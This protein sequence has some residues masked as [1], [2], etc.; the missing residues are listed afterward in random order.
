MEQPISPRAE[1]ERRRAL[2]QAEVSKLR[3][4]DDKVGSVGLWAASILAILGVAALLGLLQ[5]VWILIPVA[6]MIVARI[7][8]V[9]YDNRIQVLDAGVR[10]YDRGLARMEDRWAGQGRDGREYE[11]ADHIYAGDLDLFGK[12]S[13]F[14]L[15]CTVQTRTGEKTLASWLLR[16]GE[17]AEIRERQAAAKDLRERLDLRE[18]LAR[19]GG[20]IAAGVR[21]EELAEWGV[22]PSELS[23]AIKVLARLLT[24]ASLIT[25]GLFLA[26]VSP[27]PFA[28]AILS[29]LMFN[30]RVSGR[31]GR[32]TGLAERAER[33]LDLV[34]GVLHRVGAE[35]LTSPRLR[36]IQESMRDGASALA[37]L[38]RLI[39][40][41]QAVRNELVM[42]LAGL[43]L[44]RTHCAFALE[45][46]RA[47]WGRDVKRWLEAVGEIEALGALAVYAYENPDDPFPEIVEQGARFDGEQLGHP[48]LPRRSCV[49]ND[50]TLG[51]APRVLIVS[52]SNMSG[53]STLLRTVGV[54]AVLAL[55]GAPV[56]ARRLSIS[57]L[58]IGATIR[59][60][61]SL[62]AGMSRFYAEINRIK[63]L[64]EAA[65]GPRPLLFMLEEVLAGTN[66]QDRKT[67][68]EILLREFVAR[69]SIGLVT[70]H[71]LALAGAVDAL[72]SAAAN[73]HFEDQ[74]V[75]G[76]LT[77]DYV[78][79][80]GVVTKSN[81]LALMRAIGLLEGNGGP[82]P[83]TK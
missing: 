33:E 18:D 10:H 4:G 63:Q 31:V 65:S 62:Q 16:P 12:G 57:P 64:M 9:R 67:G 32:V 68:A 43:V 28:A 36:S 3:Q 13:L 34:S 11:P 49:R 14:E 56:R 52:G 17:P 24:A 7:I 47:R 48:L 76:K 38:A 51:D 71:D 69:K 42:A 77:F 6:V 66:S 2:K 27:Y 30:W 79:R 39:Q 15:L 40:R 81:A 72:G 44:W 41:L 19:L 54:N 55:S 5:P 53:K 1:Y 59:V 73:V 20:G 50:V 46:W 70:T 26:G 45:N 80:R 58:S 25:L 75:D 23:P 60:Q 37:R 8:H 22:A 35:S 29:I 74:L 61:D 82:G 21:P 78:L 83:S